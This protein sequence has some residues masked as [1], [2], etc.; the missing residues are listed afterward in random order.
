MAEQKEEVVMTG[1][2]TAVFRIYRDR[3]GTE[4]AVDILREARFPL[5]GH[6]RAVPRE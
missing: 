6:F 4:R 1:E 3:E 2:N 5:H